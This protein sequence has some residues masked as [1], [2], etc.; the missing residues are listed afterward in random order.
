MATKFRY[1][2]FA[3]PATR[4][5]SLNWVIDPSASIQT[6]GLGVRYRLSLADS[7]LEPNLYSLSSEQAEIAC[8]E[9]DGLVQI[10]GREDDVA[11]PAYQLK[12]HFEASRLGEL[13]VTRGRVA[14]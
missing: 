9:V 3:I 14:S 5:S 10:E 12:P 1:R 8:A 7:G 2:I 13:F 11:E 4:C 6:L